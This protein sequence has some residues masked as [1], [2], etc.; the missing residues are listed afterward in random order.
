MDEAPRSPAASE[1]FADVSAFLRPRSIAVIGA[2]DRPGNVGG[3]AVRFFRKF[4]SPCVVYPVNSRGEAVAGLPAYPTMAALPEA[5]DLAILAVPAAAV[6][7]AV[8]KCSA[9][10]TKAG[11][12]WAGGYVEGGE[13]G[14]ARQDELIAIC[15]KTGFL[16]LGP[17]CL[18]IIETH[19]PLTASFA[20][21]MFSFDR[22]LPGNISMISQSGGLA[23]IAHALAQQQTYGF[24]Y[25]ISTGNEAVLSVSDFL[26][27][28]VDDPQTK[29]IALYLEGTRDG[30]K[31]RRALTAARDAGKPVIVLKAGATGASAIAA[32][33]HTGALAGERRV[34]DAVLRECAAIRVDSL[35]ELLDVALQLSAADL[36]KL[37]SYRGVA[38]ITFG[39]GSGVL[40][41]DQCERA[42]LAVPSLSV[43]TREEL[44]AIIPPLASTRNPVDLTPQT[45]LDPQW[46][47]S[48]PRVLDVIAGDSNVGTVFFQA[49]PMSRGDAELAET[50]LE[51]RARCPKPALAAWP[52]TIDAAREVLRAGS[53]HLFP[54]YSRGVR[55]IGRLAAYS[56]D[57]SSA[58]ERPAPATFD[59]SEFLPASSPGEVVTEDRCHALLARAGMNI[60]PGRLA[61]SQNEA[62]HIAGELGAPVALKGISRQVVHRAAAGLLALS[63]QTKADVREA[64]GRITTR[65]QSRSVMLDGVYIQKMAPEGVELLLSAHRD[66]SFGVMVSIGAGGVM[67]ELIDDVILVSAPI[68]AAAATRALNHLGVVRRAGGVAG[69][70]VLPRCVARFAGLAASAPWRRFVLEINPVKW[71]A[72]EAVAVDGLLIISEP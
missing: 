40:S 55:T 45:Y 48:F 25:T 47:K 54:E 52:L 60:A 12:I 38:V 29:V 17:N 50:I 66:P 23:T 57:L 68:G 14:A 49:G 59:W 7:D 42:G 3:A 34:W 6:P 71:T 53:M 4:N 46:L 33:A 39:G 11:I 2:S 62:V 32:A 37:P 67:T 56:E 19:T 13:E 69:D 44:K 61:R 35:E 10:G 51:F 58:Y 22:L 15:R 26:R 70:G 20:S 36:S 65:A 43:E 30:E 16:A 24:R 1:E 9:A 72:N 28:L 27:A 63:L 31:I 41:A 18:G 8:L 64:W 5:A 21:M